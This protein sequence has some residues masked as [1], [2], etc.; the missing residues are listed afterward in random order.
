[1]KNISLFSLLALCTSICLA[2]S[3]V[4][5]ENESTPDA[6]AILDVQSDDK[7]ILVPRIMLESISSPDPVTNP[8]EG[9]LVYN[10]SGDLP[11]GYYYWDGSEWIFFLTPKSNLVPPGTIT[12]FA[13]PAENV[14]E[15]WLVCDGQVYAQ[16]TYPELFEAIGIAWGGS[17]DVFN[18]PDFRGHF[19]RGVDDGAGNDADAATRTNLSGDNTIGDAV[20]SYQTDAFQGHWHLL[21]DDTG[22]V[23]FTR[24]FVTGA[25][26]GVPAPASPN[27]GAL[28]RALEAV[29][30]GV[31][32]DPRLASETRPKNAYV[33]YIIKH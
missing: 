16:T 2:Q 20:G 29:S 24:G 32:G 14:P 27:N 28:T 21:G 12:A 25:G 19:L 9:L 10:N 13:G 4:I 6:S 5:S 17:G 8:T 33:H 1:M 26:S 18:V 22:E 3:V 23:G 7:G 30:D 11:K 15:G 31:N